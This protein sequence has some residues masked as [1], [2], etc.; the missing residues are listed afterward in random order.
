MSCHISWNLGLGLTDPIKL[1][2]CSCRIT[3]QCSSQQ[4]YFLTGLFAF[5]MNMYFQISSYMFLKLRCTN[6]YQIETYIT[7]Q[8]GY[9]MR[10]EVKIQ[11]KYALSLFAR[12]R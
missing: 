4:Y 10:V 5:N 9:N 2:D 8:Y 11:N 7:L 3:V 12:L 6:M 1:A